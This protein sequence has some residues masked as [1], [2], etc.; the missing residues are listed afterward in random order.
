V[1]S[2]AAEIKA[3]NEEEAMRTRFARDAAS[4]SK[5]I[6][7][8][9]SAPEAATYFGKTTQYLIKTKSFDTV[10]H[11]AS[12]IDIVKDVINLLPI[13]WLSQ[14]AVSFVSLRADAGWL[15]LMALLVSFRSASL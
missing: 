7:G 15:R 6:F 3:R 9:K 8:K 2:E 1:R 4:V 10:G 5:Y 12:Y 13:Y 14:E 11:K